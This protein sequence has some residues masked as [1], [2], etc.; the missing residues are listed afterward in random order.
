MDEL[1][2][3]SLSSAFSSSYVSSIREFD[4]LFSELKS[5]VVN[6]ISKAVKDEMEYRRFL[7][8]FFDVCTRMRDN[9]ISFACTQYVN[10][11]V[12]RRLNAKT[13]ELRVGAE[14]L[15]KLYQLT[16][17]NIQVK[18]N[19]EGVLQQLAEKCETGG[20]SSDKSTLNTILSGTGNTLRSLT[21]SRF[22]FR[23]AA[24]F[25]TISA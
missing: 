21:S 4:K 16:P 13:M 7:D 14:Y 20:T 24:P 12:V 6:T 1:N 3:N 18:E 22:L 5:K 25:R 19:L 10:G 8:L 2:A 11:Q 23:F 9:N 15:Y 17:S